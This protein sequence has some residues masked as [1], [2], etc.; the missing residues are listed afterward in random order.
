M[1]LEL[2]HLRMIIAISDSGTVTSASQ[3]LHLTQSALSHQ[4]IDLEKRLG[5]ELFHRMGRTMVPT[6]VGS[7]LL[8][9]ARNV[10]ASMNDAEDET[11]RLT[12]GREAIL[13][14]TTQCYTC[15]SWLPQLL[16]G[17]AKRFPNVDLQIVADATSRPHRAM[18]DGR[19]DLAVVHD[20]RK[21]RRLEYAP[22]FTDELAVIVPRD[23]RLAKQPF[24][25]PADLA[26]EHLIV[27]NVARERYSVFRDVL[28]PAGVRPRRVT[29]LQLTEAIVELVRSGLGISILA[30]WSLTTTLAAGDLVAVPLTEHGFQ[31]MWYAMTLVQESV[32]LHVRE[33]AQLLRHV[34]AAGAPRMR[35]A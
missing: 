7:R 31:R 2:K 11:L 35:E 34:G 16:P 6:T 13:R 30:R 3:Q 9:R 20:V 26:R 29:E 10:V 14:I 23:H 21:H 27:Y 32:P 15:Y 1:I 17:F 24:V 18:L 22:L 8:E 25:A 4:L 33:F 5:A 12:S 19:V 28:D